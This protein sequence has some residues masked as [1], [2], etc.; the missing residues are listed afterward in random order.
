MQAD[1]LKLICEQYD[2]PTGLEKVAE[3]A[4]YNSPSQTVVSGTLSELNQV[5]HDVESLGGKGI[6]LNVAGAFHS[7]LLREAEK[8]FSVY[9]LKVD[10]QPLEIPLANNVAGKLVWSP[11]S[12]K[13]SLVQQT[14]SHIY[15]WKAMQHMAKMDVI[16]EVGPGNKFSKMLKRAWPDKQI[17]SINNQEDIN[18]LLTILGKPIPIIKQEINEPIR[19]VCSR[20]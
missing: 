13:E 12:I 1:K 18:R 6:M 11:Q 9:L 4:N 2:D 8:L 20:V 16:V 3:V 15:W 7:R 5:K 10:F 17:L 19:P 14:S